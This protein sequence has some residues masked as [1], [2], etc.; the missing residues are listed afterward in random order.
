MIHQQLL[1]IGLSE[2]EAT[3]YITLLR[4]G[5]QTI[6]LLGRKAGFNR[7]T[8][9]VIL[10]ALLN[11]GLAIKSHKAKVQYFSPLNPKQLISY[12]DHKNQEINL[13]KEKIQSMMGQFTAIINPLSS[14][15]KVQFF[16][17]IEGA[18][19]VLEDTLTS[20]DKTLRAFLS[21]FDISELLGPDFFDEYTTKRVKKGYKLNAIRTLEK[22]RLAMAQYTH[23]KRYMTSK[24]E[25]R[26]IR[27]VADELAFPITMYMYDDKLAVI[28]S[29]AENF[30]LIIESKELAGMQKNL[31]QLIWSS[32]QRSVKSYFPLPARD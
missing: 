16:D 27:Y 28:S 21:I 10:H 13:Q 24:K 29:K 31:F 11:K 14:K 18:R 1:E 20:K 30:A 8:A 17:G 22:D 15:P 3:M 5:T 25:R 23:S 19:Q 12:L 4:Y 32:S 6:T 2:K 7:G 26:E 9:Y